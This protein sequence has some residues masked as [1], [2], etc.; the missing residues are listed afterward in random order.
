ML[1]GDSNTKCHQFIA[2]SQTTSQDWPRTNRRLKASSRE[3]MEHVP[4]LGLKRDQTWD[5]ETQELHTAQ[6]QRSG[7]LTGK[8][9]QQC[10]HRR[11]EEKP[12]SWSSGGFG[13]MLALGGMQAGGHIPRITEGGLVCPL[14]ICCSREGRKLLLDHSWQRSQDQPEH[15]EKAVS[16]IGVRERAGRSSQG[17]PHLEHR[18]SQAIPIWA[19]RARL[20]ARQ[21]CEPPSPPKDWAALTSSSWL[22]TC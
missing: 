7:L 1:F 4:R 6:K 5:F 11:E 2:G 3:V 20:P 18:R 16:F 8:P 10:L 17:L 9:V 12:K 21:G 14:M 19:P 13:A 15:R 22:W